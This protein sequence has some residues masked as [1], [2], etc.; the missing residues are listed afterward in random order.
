MD[1][2]QELIESPV[3]CEGCGL[4]K[5]QCHRIKSVSRDAENRPAVV[6]FYADG[7]MTNEVTREAAKPPSTWVGV[8]LIVGAWSCG[9]V[10]GL[11]LARAAGWL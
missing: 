5:C 8:V 9:V 10:C 11:L 1:F 7:D 3:T 6:L 2:Y 4:A